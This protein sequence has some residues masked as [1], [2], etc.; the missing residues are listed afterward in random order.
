[1]PTIQ[2]FN[3]VCILEKQGNLYKD[4][5]RSIIRNNKSNENKQNEQ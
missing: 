4:I 3:P 2:Q 5:Q 1:M